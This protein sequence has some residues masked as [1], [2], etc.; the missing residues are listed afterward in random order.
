MK[1]ALFVLLA[2][3]LLIAPVAA[4][5]EIDTDATIT[6]A[7]TTIID[8]MD[9]MIQSTLNGSGIFQMMYDELIDMNFATAELIPGLATEW[10]VSEDGKTW[11]FKLREGVNFHDGTPLTAKDVKY[12]YERMLVDDYNIGN[13]NYLNNQI[14]FD[15]IDIIDDYTFD[16]VTKEPVPALLYSLQ[17]VHI[18]P[19]H[20][21][22]ER[23][24]EEAA[25]LPL[26][27]SG[28]FKFVE[29]A[30][31]D[32]VKME[33]NDEYWGNVPQFKTLIYRMIPEASTRIAEL[34][35]GGIDVAQ[36]IP[37]AQISVVNDSGVATVKA[38][39]NGCRMILGFNH[40]NPKFSKNVRFAINH[41]I[42][43][44][45][46]NQSFFFGMAPRMII[47]VNAPWLNPDLEAYP[48]D[49][50]KA[51][52]YMAADGYEKDAAG[53]WAKDGTELEFNI[54]VY[55]DQ[56]SERYEVLL[57]LL[58]MLNK[59]G[60]KAEAYYLDRAAA[61]EKLD[62][63][64]IDDMYYIGSCTS[65][66]PQGDLTD[67]KAD[68][69]SNYGRWNNPEFE[70]VFNQLISE[71]D[72]EK[73]AELSYKLEEIAYNDAA[74]VPLYIIIDTWGVSNKLDWNPSP[75]GRAWMKGAT[76]SAD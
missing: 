5:A 43:W 6:V 16:F 35:T 39:P 18:L 36:S 40:E 60:F 58:D 9:Y 14:L 2:I 72:V 29:Y 71:F 24:P 53:F 47:N 12:T 70:E 73:R 50:D 52:E 41:S 49:L 62:Q 30:K 22:A 11:H 57:S 54:M 28:A 13:T 26:V 67:L 51:A 21:Y 56:S 20:I 25:T 32:Y 19:E 55:Y 10:T 31:D 68:S 3:V 59:A 61:I 4:F 76:K 37:M 66:E 48:F 15:H 17:E 69:A 46:I 42:D 63:R 65:Y 64:Q 1:K 74:V 27:G 75:T 23:S 7:Q 34:E 33:R 38:V 45:A 44:E 8:N